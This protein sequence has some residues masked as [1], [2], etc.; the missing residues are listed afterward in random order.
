MIRGTNADCRVLR[1]SVS[2]STAMV[3][4]LVF[5]T[6][7]TVPA[8]PFR[9]WIRDSKTG[10]RTLADNNV[11]W[12]DRTNG[13]DGDA[14]NVDTNRYKEII[15]SIDIT[16]GGKS[17]VDG[18]RWVRECS[19]LMLD[20][21]SASRDPA[22][23][24]DSIRLVSDEFEVPEVSAVSM[25]TYE[26]AFDE[27]L[28]KPVAKIGASFRLSFRSQADFNYCDEN[29]LAEVNVRS[30]ATDR[31]LETKRLAKSTETENSVRMDSWY[32]I[33]ES[34]AFEILV[35][36]AKGNVFSR[37]RKIFVPRK[38]WSQGAYAK[39]DDGVRK[40]RAFFVS[41]DPKEQH[42]GDWLWE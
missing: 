21:S 7:A 13:Y 33:G 15:L 38:R 19:I 42:E 22:W 37:T 1:V 9:F 12:V 31:I 35:T 2:E 29:F 30:A 3:S 4:L 14:N 8:K 26:E 16:D 5:A 6:V 27:E 40:V 24:S 34:V 11:Y 28:G 23:G 39:T 20:D 32:Q 25:G 41:T 18:N 36:D 17:E 10:E